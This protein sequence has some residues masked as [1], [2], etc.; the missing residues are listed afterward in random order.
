MVG[1]S[2]RVWNCLSDILRSYCTNLAYF[3]IDFL[4]FYKDALINIYDS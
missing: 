4:E 3:K 2:L 1:L